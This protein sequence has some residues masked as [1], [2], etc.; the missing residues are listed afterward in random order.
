MI[1]APDFLLDGRW[2]M[3][4]SQ[5]TVVPGDPVPVTI[6]PAVYDTYIGRYALAAGVFYQITRSGNRLFMQ[7]GDEKQELFPLGETRFFRNGRRG[8]VIFDT[9]AGNKAGRLI[10]RRDNNDIV[11][12]RVTE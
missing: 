8:E 1:V 6:D 4:A 12:K 5:V 10:L 3:I 11:L 2:Q 9:V 7:R